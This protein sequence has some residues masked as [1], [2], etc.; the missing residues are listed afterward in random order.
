MNRKINFSFRLWLCLICSLFVPQNENVLS[1][2]LKLSIVIELGFCY[3][4][5]SSPDSMR[6]L[7][8][9]ITFAFLLSFATQSV[10]AGVLT[11]QDV[12]KLLDAKMPE[13]VILQAIVSGQTKFDT[14][15]T[16]LIK[17]RERGDSD[18][19][20]SHA[21]PAE[22][23]KANQTASKE[24]AGA[25]Q[26]RSPMSQVTQRRLQSWSTV[27]RQICSTLFHK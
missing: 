2:F 20:E 26:K 12:I 4:N 16:A 17:L 23:G 18:Y 3:F 1:L 5:F 25:G 13:D 9:K 6:T 15:P 14:S 11:N 7:F 10:F 8:S 27:L 24:K 21:N 22:F 19:S